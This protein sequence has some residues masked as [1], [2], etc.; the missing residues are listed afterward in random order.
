LK[1]QTVIG[2]RKAGGEEEL[3]HRKEE[4]DREA[5]GHFGVFDLRRACLNSK[6]AN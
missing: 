3:H 5:R 2:V 4:K 6:K 1:L